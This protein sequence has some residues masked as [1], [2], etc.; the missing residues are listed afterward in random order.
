MTKEPSVRALCE[1][2]EL[3]AELLREAYATGDAS[4]IDSALI[5]VTDA[6]RM[7]QN[8]L[9]DLLYADEPEDTGRSASP[10]D[11]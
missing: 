9:Y 10:S 5:Q 3:Q 7:M 2:V 4:A 1:N 11:T 6:R 8:G